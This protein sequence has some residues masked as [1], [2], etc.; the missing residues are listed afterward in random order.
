[1]KKIMLILTSLILMSCSSIGINYTPDARHGN[2]SVSG[3]TGGYIN[4]GF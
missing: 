2:V 3:N 4:I 1:M